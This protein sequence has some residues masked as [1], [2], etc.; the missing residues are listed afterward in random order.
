MCHYFYILKIDVRVGRGE[1]N[2][3][4]SVTRTGGWARG[5]HDWRQTDFLE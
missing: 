3:L 5:P 1:S 2:V 4:P